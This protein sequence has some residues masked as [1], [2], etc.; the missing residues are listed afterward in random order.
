M[1]QRGLGWFSLSL[2]HP[3]S[4][5]SAP[6]QIQL[7]VNIFW[8]PSSS[9]QQNSPLSPP[10]W[11]KYQIRKVSCIIPGKR[12]TLKRLK[13]LH[14]EC[15]HFQ[16]SKLRRKP[17][18]C[19][20]FTTCLPMFQMAAVCEFLKDQTHMWASPSNYNRRQ[21]NVC[22]HVSNQNDKI[23]V[24]TYSELSHKH[25]FLL[26]TMPFG[27]FFT[28]PTCSFS[29]FFLFLPPSSDSKKWIR[30]T[31][32]QDKHLW[33]SKNFLFIY[34]EPGPLITQNTSTFLNLI[35]RFITHRSEI[36][37]LIISSKTQQHTWKVRKLNN[38]FY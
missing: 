19:W 35:W 15:F 3:P 11:I 22:P 12:Q 1:P 10:H 4:L 16:Q 37:G 13:D 5:P 8:E 38:S 23:K 34:P 6:P 17:E 25:F 7:F 2:P 29:L 24:Y 27:I 30:I 28:F 26:L 31:V 21:G 36:T 18:R 20:R 14:A 9:N 33:E 32:G